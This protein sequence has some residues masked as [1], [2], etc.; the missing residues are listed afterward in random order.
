MQV[1]MLAA[2]E[3]LGLDCRHG[4]IGQAREQFGVGW[5][6]ALGLKVFDSLFHGRLRA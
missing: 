1:G 2:L 4:R 6:D 5:L 3:Y